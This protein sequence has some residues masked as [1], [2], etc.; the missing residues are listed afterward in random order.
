MT[1]VRQVIV[2]DLGQVVAVGVVQTNAHQG[3]AIQGN[4]TRRKGEVLAGLADRLSSPDSSTMVAAAVGSVELF[5]ISRVNGLSSIPH[6][7]LL[8]RQ[9]EGRIG[10]GEGTAPPVKSGEVVDHGL[11]VAA[12][13][14]IANQDV[15][16]VVLVLDVSVDGQDTN[17]S[18]LF[19]DGL[20]GVDSMVVT[21][22]E[23][24]SRAGFV[25]VEVSC[26]T[27]SKATR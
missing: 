25:S 3:S 12:S 14:H 2:E 9:I 11:D 6:Q 17:T 1:A 26:R 16:V 27:G 10:I 21:V 8:V 4:V 22:R 18:V 15:L 7:R 23:Q 24:D 19:D 13:R 5:N 20:D